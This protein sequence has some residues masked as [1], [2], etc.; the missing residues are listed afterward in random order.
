MAGRV[1]RALA[2]RWKNGAPLPGL[3]F[4]LSTDDGAPRDKAHDLELASVAVRAAARR[5]GI[6]CKALLERES[7]GRRWSSLFPA[8]RRLE[9]SGEL[10]SGRFF[11]GMDGPQFMDRDALR[12]FRDGF[13]EGRLWSVNAVD[14]A[15]P[16]GVSAAGLSPRLPS[17][18]PVNRLSSRGGEPVCVSRRSWRELDIFAEADDPRLEAAFAFMLEARR[19]VVSPERRIPVES[20]NGSPAAESPYAGLFARLG[21]DSDRGALTLW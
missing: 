18:I 19:R 10:V 15:S 11:D 2:A 4:S 20:I 21:F 7:P 16:C 3:W 14:P 12:L 13:D 6:V 5:Y 17:R 8:I 1:P 9:L